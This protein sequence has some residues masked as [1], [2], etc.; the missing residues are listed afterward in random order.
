MRDEYC[1]ECE[2]RS[3]VIDAG[4]AGGAVLV[5]WAVCTECGAESV[6]RDDAPETVTTS[7]VVRAAA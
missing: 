5:A 3:V 1:V 4:D 7:V 2:T 6:W